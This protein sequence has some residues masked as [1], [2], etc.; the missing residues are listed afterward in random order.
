MIF[1]K[2][3]KSQL[4]SDLRFLLE[5]HEHLVYILEK[6]EDIL[7]TTPVGDNLAH[8]FDDAD[9]RADIPEYDLMQRNELKKF[10]RLLESDADL[11]ELCRISFLQPSS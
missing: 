6:Y 4:A 10:I 8:F 5:N 7:I 11:S 9:I 1:T 3:L 2:E